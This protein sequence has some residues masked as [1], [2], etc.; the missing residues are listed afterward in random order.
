MAIPI[1]PTI[2]KGG[3][4][5]SGVSDRWAAICPVVHA[6]HKQPGLAAQARF[7]PWVRVSAGRF[8]ARRRYK[9]RLGCINRAVYV[10]AASSDYYIPF[11]VASGVF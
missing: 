5:T 11:Q 10:R 9:P 8:M 4:E 2:F 1:S 6:T 7:M 3:D